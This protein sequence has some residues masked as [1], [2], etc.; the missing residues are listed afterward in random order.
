MV[1]ANPD[2]DKT[3]LLAP[4]LLYTVGDE[5]FSQFHLKFYRTLKVSNTGN[6]P[7]FTRLDAVSGIKELPELQGRGKMN[8]LD[9]IERVRSKIS[10]ACRTIT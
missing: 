9:F 10:V 4:D 7:N 3:F 1:W 2:P 5:F 8:L 6:G